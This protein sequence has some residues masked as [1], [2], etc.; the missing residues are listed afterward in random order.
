MWGTCFLGVPRSIDTLAFALA[1]FA[2]HSSHLRALF[3]LFDVFCFVLC[4][5]F[6]LHSASQFSHFVPHSSHLRRSL[7]TFRILVRI[8]RICFAPFALFA[9]CFALLAFCSV[10][11]TF[12]FTFFAFCY[13]LFAFFVPNITHFRKVFTVIFTYVNYLPVIFYRVTKQQSFLLT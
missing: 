6:F 7:R 13:V 5:A 9:F 3:A 8:F 4:F 12:C 11:F 10:F 2:P 1:H